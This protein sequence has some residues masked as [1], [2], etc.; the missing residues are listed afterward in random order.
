MENLW[1]KLVRIVYAEGKQYNCVNELK[2]AIFDAWN[3]IPP[4]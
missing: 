1:S 3:S 4:T 2:N